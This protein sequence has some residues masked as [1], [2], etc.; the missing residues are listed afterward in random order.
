MTFTHLHV[1]TEYSMLDG[2]SK[3]EKLV[4]RASELG[5]D[6]LAITDH[7]GMYGVVEFYTACQSAGI[8]PIIGCELYVAPG[9]HTDRSSTDKNPFHLSVLAQNNTGYRNLMQLVTKANLEGFYYKPRI[10]KELLVTETARLKSMYTVVNPSPRGTM[11]P[12]PSKPAAP[13]LT[14]P[15]PAVMLTIFSVGDWLARSVF[16]KAPRLGVPP[17][18]LGSLL[19]APVPK[20]SRS[21]F[22]PSVAAIQSP[23]P[24]RSEIEVM[25]TKPT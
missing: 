10:S 11:M 21:L 15:G 2:L 17:S 6:S 22:E 9:L 16:P 8:K 14:E 24:A 1:H 4:A 19:T 23:K 18:G 25:S 3:I 13:F 7:G 12:G 5:M 20:S